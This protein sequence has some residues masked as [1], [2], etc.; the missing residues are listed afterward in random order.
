MMIAL[1]GRQEMHLEFYHLTT[2]AA[3][4]FIYS[5]LRGEKMIE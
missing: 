1:D 3:G 4:V 5:S 2:S